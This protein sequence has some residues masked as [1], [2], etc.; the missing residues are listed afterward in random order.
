MQYMN[1]LIFCVCCFSCILRYVLLQ[2]SQAEHDDFPFHP[3]FGTHHIFLS[4]YASS[5]SSHG[6]YADVLLCACLSIFSWFLISLVQNYLIFL[7][8]DHKYNSEAM[9]MCLRPSLLWRRRRRRRLWFKNGKVSQDGLLLCMWP[10]CC[11]LIICS[12]V[13][14]FL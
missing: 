3:S 10:I 1:Y 2:R 11:H 9:M 8:Q 13:P 7:V 14:M 12:F 5:W 6:F 4:I